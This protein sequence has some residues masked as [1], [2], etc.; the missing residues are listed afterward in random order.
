MRGVEC[1]REAALVKLLG[2]HG[3]FL[4]AVV[5]PVKMPADEEEKRQASL[6]L[7]RKLLPLFPKGAVPKKYRFVES[8]P[9]NPQGK[10]RAAELAEMFA[11]RGVQ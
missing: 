1:V 7:R 8:L 5:V 10:V 3:D 9:R 2:A 6:D 11:E 4:G